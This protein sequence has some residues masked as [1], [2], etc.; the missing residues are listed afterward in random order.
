MRALR[1]DWRASAHTPVSACRQ[2]P[3]QSAKR[4]NYN[5]IFKSHFMT[6]KPHQAPTRN[7]KIY[8]IWSF[9]EENNLP[10]R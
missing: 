7:I 8:A 9:N 4:T 6:T 10:E 2:S 5:T 3:V 1:G